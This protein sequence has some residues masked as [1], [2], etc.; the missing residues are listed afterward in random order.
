MRRV[1]ADTLYWVAR[2]NPRD[3]WHRKVNGL[4]AA[5]GRTP[6]VTTDE[7]L[8]EVLNHF[9]SGGPTA[10]SRAVAVV[11]SLL[12][13]PAVEILPQSRRSF[14]AGLDLYEARLDKGYSLTDCISMDTMRREG[15][16]EVLTADQHF[17]QEG[18]TLLL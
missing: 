14:L 5:L 18:F 12:V 15:I 7:V 11:R 10:R 3:Q 8:T 13:Q 9:S 4:V 16:A 1:F 6:V 2:I 17:A